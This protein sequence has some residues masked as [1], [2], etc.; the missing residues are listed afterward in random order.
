MSTDTL[1]ESGI[2]LVTHGHSRRRQSDSVS[3]SV[4]D[5]T[6]RGVVQSEQFA[7]WVAENW[8]PSLPIDVWTSS[9]RR[10]MH[11]AKVSKRVLESTG[12]AVAPIQLMNRLMKV[13]DSA[14]HRANLLAVLHSA[15][16]HLVAALQPRLMI[17]VTHRA[18]L[19]P[20]ARILER[21]STDIVTTTAFVLRPQGF[22]DF[23][24]ADTHLFAKPAQPELHVVLRLTLMTDIA[25][26]GNVSL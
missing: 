2:V 24:L 7:R 14:H 4:R 21:P 6:E 9:T 26:R 17:L 18:L 11:T 5:L 23:F 16:D 10:T 13:G 25:M 3:T 12:R 1:S 20:I 8:A 22:G 15:H 19:E